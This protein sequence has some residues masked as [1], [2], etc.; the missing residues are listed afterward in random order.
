MY[1][2]NI[3]ALAEAYWAKFDPAF[4]KDDEDF[5]EDE[6]EEEEEEEESEE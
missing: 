4:Q 2:P 5:Q 3:D 6:E 1:E